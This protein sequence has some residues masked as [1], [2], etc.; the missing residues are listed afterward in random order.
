MHLWKQKFRKYH[1]LQK[2]F[3]QAGF[4][5]LPLICK[6][7]I[8]FVVFTSFLGNDNL[9]Q[10]MTIVG[11]SLLFEVNREMPRFIIRKRYLTIL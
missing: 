2:R 11:G 7:G 10:R 8:G 3:E 4:P 9:I 1:Q 5:I 6:D